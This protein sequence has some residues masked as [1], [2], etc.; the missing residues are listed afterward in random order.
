MTDHIT[1]DELQ[2]LVEAVGSED[3]K[4][5]P[6]ETLQ[7]C[8]PHIRYLKKL[9]RTRKAAT[10]RK[11]KQRER[12]RVAQKLLKTN[13][14]M[15]TLDLPSDLVPLTRET[16]R[17]YQKEIDNLRNENVSLR[18]QYQAMANEVREH[19]VHNENVQQHINELQEEIKH[20]ESLKHQQQY[21]LYQASQEPIYSDYVLRCLDRLLK[22]VYETCRVT[23]SSL[24][25]CDRFTQDFSF[26]HAIYSPISITETSQTT[27][28]PTV[29]DAN[30]VPYVTQYDDYPGLAE[31]RSDLVQKMVYV[32]SM[33]QA[34]L[35]ESF[36]KQIKATPNT[37]DEDEPR[38]IAQS[39][40]RRLADILPYGGSWFGN[41]K[42]GTSDTQEST[43]A[44]GLQTV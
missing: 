39:L 16:I 25:F 41:D 22:T 29:F 14:S 20:L 5:H 18:E 35:L 40:S 17:E 8:W 12:A 43:G 27:P 7:Q 13:A 31:T 1:L 9:E 6:V 15:S 23:E 44:T 19:E 4:D 38:T 10:Q 42:T 24:H 11:R 34:T 21:A 37:A 30:L 28:P 32:T 26:S 2:D 33:L 36:Q 3:E